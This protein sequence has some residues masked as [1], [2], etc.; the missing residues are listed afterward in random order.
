MTEQQ[1][2]ALAISAVIVYV[3]MGSKLRRKLKNQGL[4]LLRLG[5]LGL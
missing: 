4:E 2:I 5:K 1:T 3:G